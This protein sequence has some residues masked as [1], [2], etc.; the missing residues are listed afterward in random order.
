MGFVHR[1]FVAAGVG[2]AASA[3]VGCGGSS[4]R[5]L[6][7][8]Q[9]NRLTAQLNSVT[10]ALDERRCAAA[11]SA[12][13]Q[14]EDYVSSLHAVDS[15]LVSNLT[16]GATTI[17]QLTTTNCDPDTPT[18]TA[19][20]RTA[21][22]RTATTVTTDTTTTPTTTT[23]TTDT[24]STPTYTYTPT[25][26]TGGGGI[27]SPTTPASTTTPTLPPS[28]GQGLGGQAPPG[29]SPPGTA[30]TDTTSTSSSGYSYGGTDTTD[31]SGG[32]NTDTTSSGPGF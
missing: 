12:L 29:Q 16:Q 6:S 24:Y 19:T 25:N 28:G 26:T 31:T 8:S 18:R 4:G 11:Q 14:F 21:T 3:I 23:V 27:T 13:A 5:L 22:T 32:Y 20:T 9:A 17:Q 1:A 10:S 7:Q 30:P 15:T 2:F